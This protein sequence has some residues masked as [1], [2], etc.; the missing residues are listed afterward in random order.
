MFTLDEL[1][2]A[3]AVVRRHFAPTPQLRWPVL[4][5]E[6]GLDVVVKHENLTPVGAF[7]VRGGLVYVDSMLRDRPAVTGIVSATRGNHGQSLAYAGVRAGV[8]VTIV[9][10]KG[11]SVEKNAAMRA[12]GADLVEFGHDFQAA[13]EHASLLANANGWEAV[14]SFHPDLVR[15]VAT[16][17]KELFDAEG[18]LDVV[19]APLGMGSG[20]AGLIG[21]RDML[22]LHTEIVAVVA[23]GAPAYALSVEAGHVVETETADTFVDGCACRVPD[24]TALEVVIGG[25]ARMSVVEDAVTADAMRLVFRSTHHLAEPAGAIAFGAV[26]DDRDRLQGQRVGVILSGCNLDTSLAAEVLAG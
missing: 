26:L 24:P 15:G 2:D 16:Y 4:S 25:V 23:A 14:A 22:G 21:V 8:K 12:Q 1:N 18:A 5:A 7:K 9:V 19:Y 3:T 17:A 20:V 10:P 6:L 11:N 13:R